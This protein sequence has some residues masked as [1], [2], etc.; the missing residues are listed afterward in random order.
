MKI[1]SVEFIQRSENGGAPIDNEYASKLRIGHGTPL[2]LMP[3]RQFVALLKRAQ[4]AAR[5]ME[6]DYDFIE[7][8]DELLKEHDQF[9]VPV[10]IAR[11]SNDN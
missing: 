5:E 10:E 8:I 11:V 2:I 3:K 6:V 9:V 4:E 1:T 7:E